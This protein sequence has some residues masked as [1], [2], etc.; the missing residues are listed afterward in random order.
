MRYHAI[1]QSQ[2]YLQ[3][4]ACPSLI[5]KVTCPMYYVA[6]LNRKLR[7]NRPSFLNTRSCSQKF[8][9][10]GILREVKRLTLLLSYLLMF[11]VI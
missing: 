9:H 7:G 6:E 5:E 10:F 3:G 2:I 11:C 1:S 4:I 8:I